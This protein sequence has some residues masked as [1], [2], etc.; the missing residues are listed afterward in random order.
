M[1]IVSNSKQEEVVVSISQERINREDS[2]IV[3]KIFL[4][5]AKDYMDDLEK[6]KGASDQKFMDKYNNDEFTKYWDD[7]Q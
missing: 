1:S 7:A 5:R 3:L 6:S 4:T 2:L